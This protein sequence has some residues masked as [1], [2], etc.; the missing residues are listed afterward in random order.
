MEAAVGRFAGRA[1]VVGPVAVVMPESLQLGGDFDPRLRRPHPQEPED[2]AGN[3]QGN[4]LF[5][6]ASAH[7][8]DTEKTRLRRLRFQFPPSRSAGHPSV[9]C[10][11]PEAVN[12]GW[13]FSLKSSILYR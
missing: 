4:E 1:Q 3:Q 11:H 12:P 9:G 5:Q 6:E 10:N 8:R 2:S 13:H 7:F